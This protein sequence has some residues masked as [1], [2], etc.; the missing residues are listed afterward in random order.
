MGSRFFG[1]EP[2]ETNHP[3][4]CA[5]LVLCFDSSSSLSLSSLA[6][7]NFELA[8]KVNHIDWATYSKKNSILCGRTSQV[9]RP[10]YSCPYPTDLRQPCR[11][12]WSLD[13]FGI[14]ILYL[15]QERF[16]RHT[17]I[18]THRRNEYAEAVTITYFIF[19]YRKSSIIIIDQSKYKSAGVI[20]LYNFG[21][22]KPLPI[23]S[24]KF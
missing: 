4:L 9:I 7:N 17:D 15:A 18:T 20:L 3:C 13:K 12:T 8:P 10:T 2:L 22:Q 14:Y 6:C 16:T 5:S 19:K 21:R 23:N 24:K 11:C 1:I